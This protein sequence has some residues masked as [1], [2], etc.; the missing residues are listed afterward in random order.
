[1]TK[2]VVPPAEGLRT[3]VRFSPPPPP[4]VKFGKRFIGV[5]KRTKSTPIGSGFLMK[6]KKVNNSRRKVTQYLAGLPV[7]CVASV[8]SAAKK[9]PAPKPFRK[10]TR[11]E[12]RYQNEPYIGRACAKCMLYQGN[13][14]CVILDDAVS[15]DG[16]CSEWTP[17]T[18]G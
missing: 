6:N 3:G 14:L 9:R 1:M 12:V 2:H 7:I 11:E 15:P 8:A 18:V 13:G 10:R 4:A 17:G 16:W 5:A